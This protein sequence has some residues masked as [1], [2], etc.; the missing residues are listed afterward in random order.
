MRRNCIIARDNWLLVYTAID[1]KTFQIY[2]CRT[3]LS[4]KKNWCWLVFVLVTMFARWWCGTAAAM[5]SG[6]SWW[7]WRWHWWR[8]DA[9]FALASVTA[10]AALTSGGSS[11]SR[12]RKYRRWSCSNSRGWGRRGSPFL[13]GRWFSFTSGRSATRSVTLP[14]FWWRSWR[15][16]SALSVMD[17]RFR[18]CASASLTASLLV[19][20][21]TFVL[22]G[23][24]VTL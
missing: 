22:L 21:F 3:N 4:R 11:G 24:S 12:R 9:S 1:W 2:W 7:W 16:S 6:T 18:R 14:R 5:F 17:W 19:S 23:V 20:I 15:N 8:S 13:V 10:F